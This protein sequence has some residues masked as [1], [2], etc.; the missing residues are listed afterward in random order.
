MVEKQTGIQHFYIEGDFWD[1]E[2]YRIEDRIR[3]I[4]NISYFLHMEKMISI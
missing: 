2:N 1:D 3:Q 4:E